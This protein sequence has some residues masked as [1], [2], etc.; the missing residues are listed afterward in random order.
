MT[1]AAVAEIVIVLGTVVQ[2]YQYQLKTSYFLFYFS[3][4]SDTVSEFCLPGEF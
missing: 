2:V 4:F 1:N 3:S